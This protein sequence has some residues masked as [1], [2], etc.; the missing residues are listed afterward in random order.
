M[1]LTTVEVEEKRMEFMLQYI[2]NA[3]LSGRSQDIDG[4]HARGQLVTAANDLFDQVVLKCTL[5]PEDL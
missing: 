2:L 1:P 5:I 4:T 3:R